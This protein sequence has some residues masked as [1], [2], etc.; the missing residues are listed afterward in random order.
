MTGAVIYRHVSGLAVDLAKDLTTNRASTTAGRLFQARSAGGFWG[1]PPARVGPEGGGC[2]D[3][4]GATAGTCH[5]VASQVFE[6]LWHLAPQDTRTLDFSSKTRISRDCSSVTGADSRIARQKQRVSTRD[7][8]ND[9][10]LSPHSA[11]G[12]IPSR[13]AWTMPKP[14]SNAAT[15][16]ISSASSRR[17]L[18]GRKDSRAI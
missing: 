13:I 17:K 15:A 12:S 1:P 3:Q 4:N 7:P 2:M 6:M 14:P 10:E 8:L 9:S 11:N 18:P 5:G 16:S